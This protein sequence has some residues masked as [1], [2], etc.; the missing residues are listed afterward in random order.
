MGLW[1]LSG[2]LFAALCGPRYRWEEDQE[3][4]K[5]YGRASVYSDN[6]SDIDRQSILSW[7][8]RERTRLRIID[9]YEFCDIS[10]RRRWGCGYGYSGGRKE[11]VDASELLGT[12]GLPFSTGGFEGIEKLMAAIGLPVSDPADIEARQQRLIG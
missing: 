8:L 11:S 5:A 1:I 10:V 7:S 4:H 3:K 2:Q 12:A 6:L 9:A